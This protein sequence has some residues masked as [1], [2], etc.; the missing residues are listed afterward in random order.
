MSGTDA[1]LAARKTLDE[2]CITPERIISVYSLEQHVWADSNSEDAIR[3]RQPELQTI[4][5]F[6]IDPVRPFLNDI[7][8]NI[9]APYKPERKDNPIGQGYWIQAEFGSGKSHL[10]CCLAALALGNQEAW[11]LIQQKE[12]KAGRGK[13]ESLYQFWEDGLKVKSTGGKKGIFVIVM[14]LVGV[15]GGTI[16]TTN[17][18]AK[19]AEY[20][21][22]AAKKQIKA[23]LGKNLSLYP[24]ELLADKFIADQDLYRDRLKKFLKNP[25]FFDED[26]FEDVDDFIQ[27][28]QQNRSPEYKRSCGNK[29][30]RFYTEDLGVQPQIAAETEDILKHMVEIILAEGYSGVL[31]VLDEVSL[32]MK[33]RDDDQRADDEK[34]LVVLSN[35]LAKVHNLPIWT[36]CS[37][38]QALESKMGVK[39]II[40]DDRLKLVKLLEGDKDYYN[41]VLSRVREIKDPSAIAN[42]YLYYKRGFTWPNSI[43]LEEFSHFFPFHK[44]AL[45]VLRAITSE[46]TTARSAIHFMHQTL[47]HQIKHQGQELIR[48]WELFDEA[49][50]YEEDPSGVLSG[51]AAIKTKR[52]QDYVA[53]E[54]CKRQIDGL[55]KGTLKFYH[56]RAIKIIQTLFLYHISRTRQQGISPEEISNSVLIER[57]PDANPDENIQHYESLSEHLKKELRQIAH[58]V[59]E[60]GQP[61]YRFDPVF[62]GVDPRIEFSKARDLAE[63]NEVMQKEARDHLL[64]LDV[65][66]VR[67]RQM[68]LDLS[69][70]VR[71]IFIRIAAKAQELEINWQGR[72]T[73][74]SV[75][76][77][78]LGQVAA[79]DLPLPEIDSPQTDQDFAVFIG[80][81]PVP[82]TTI[83]K[84]LARRKDPR[85]LIW[86]PDEFTS[87]ERDRLLDFT[88]Y[89]KLV[90]DY[91]GKDTEDAVAVINWVSNALQ[92]D[93]AKIAK[94][95][96]NSYA[97][98]R[99]DALN[100]TQ[101][102]FRVAGGLESTLAPLI[103]R[104]LTATYESRDIKFDA[105]FTLRKE[106][107]V[108]V[109]NGVVKTGSIPKGAKPNQN[110]SAA[111]NFG[112]G[113]KI[114]KK[115]A[116]RQLDISE[117]SHAQAILSFIETNLVDDGSTLKL[118]SLYKNFMGIGSSNGKN[119]GLTR[120]M[121]QIYLLC[122][123]QQ[124]KIRIHLSS[125]S[126]LPESFIDYSNVADIDFSVKVL[127]AWT[128]VQ[129]MAKPE[130][131]EILS[132]YASKILG[133]D[134]PSTHD[135]AKISEYRTKLR[136]LFSAEK[137]D[138]RRVVEKASSLFGTL[139]IANPYEQEIQ[140]IARLFATDI[141]SGDDI[142]LL[143]YGLQQVLKYQAFD[144][145]V[146]S[147]AEV[148]DLANRLRN[149]KDLKQFLTH[150]SD[151][152]TAYAYCTS[153]PANVSDLQQAY[154]T[155]DELSQKIRHLRP[156]IDSDVKLKTELIGQFPPEPGETG[157]ISA[158]LQEYGIVY[159]TLHDTV[160]NELDECR[161]SIEGLMSSPDLRAL[162]ILE[163]ITALQPSIHNRIQAELTRLS[164]QIFSC[165]DASRASIEKSLRTTPVHLCGLTF[166]NY[167]T[168]LTD[169]KQAVET[170]RCLVED[171]I[172]RKMEVFLNPSVQE[173][174]QQ[175]IGEAAIAQL[176]QCDTIT[177]VRDYL[178]STSL[179]DA[180]IVSTINQYLK[181]IMVKTVKLSDFKPSTTTVQPDQIAAIAQEFQTY[182]EQQLNEVGQD[183]D[184]LPILQL[185]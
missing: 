27:A 92:S 51:I 171:A 166:D 177:S 121:V 48:L 84:L 10:L 16:G 155:R 12:Q 146:S 181:R 107:G 50:R 96:E 115:S 72:Q 90:A 55:T 93:M 77:K 37:A 61:R 38:Q 98:G 83:S 145:G 134:I 159:A 130:N 140:Q 43:G 45:E 105:P 22:D 125:R 124:G 33:N 163:G 25:K 138:A 40:A 137:Q 54:A 99:V 91:Q 13:R 76:L 2:I 101:M 108:K 126:G 97:R 182:L 113:L 80:K 170:A 151:L 23:E 34:T 75:S 117:N 24:T 132:P 17:K 19:L 147:P 49:V 104:V 58:S 100:N 183:E 81:K 21:I 69:N 74:G 118:E 144:K 172:D 35:R 3:D 150:E 153:L 131:W 44:P 7:L 88:A 78:D 32:F 39:N 154:E 28:I 36:V 167:E 82:F 73:F 41:I 42:Y 178:I 79:D 179:E 29:L 127:D 31:L 173:R 53:Y 116:E 160:I 67:T 152:K 176:L 102:E 18:G 63:S 57:K 165:K 14:T 26:E 71:S 139:N 64:A 136:E 122:L 52:E 95:I 8:R 11:N 106:E 109:I 120:R 133:E 158:L 129:K 148:D 135:D 174:L 87:E 94:V 70:G 128:E 184:T 68:T 161:Q 114:M 86:T 4:E 168:Y 156:Y 185:E 1:L 142:N 164:E 141:E 9:A 62:T 162:K 169:A 15:G 66:T 89:R 56:D 5:E 149:Y 123:V 157:T 47:K 6:Q 119:Y 60:D 46:L 180:S 112:F 110:I 20:I 143:L 103:D 175:G 30:W 111:Q 85:I 59:D 65:W